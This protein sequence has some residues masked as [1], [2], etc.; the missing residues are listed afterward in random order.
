MRMVVGG[1]ACPESLMRGLDRFGMRV[2]HAWGMTETTPL[3]TVSFMKT[4]LD[5]TDEDACYRIR[6]KQGVP[7]PFVEVRAVAETGPVPHDGAAMGELEVRG[8]WVAARY[9][10]NEEAQDRWTADGW[11]GTSTFTR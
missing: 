1:S 9:Y 5:A 7:V 8:P 4:S 2:V 3:G 10:R 11:S 6:A